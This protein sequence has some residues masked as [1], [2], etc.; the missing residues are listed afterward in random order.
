MKKLNILVLAGLLAISGTVCAS[1]SI[2]PDKLFNDYGRY[3]VICMDSGQRVYID[4]NTLLRDPAPAG[5]LPV[6][7]GTA[8]TEVYESLDF[9]AYGNNKMIKMIVESEIAVGAD[10]YGSDVKYSMLTQNKGA[11]DAGG[12][13]VPPDGE[14]INDTPDT[15]K[16]IYINM[17]R[18]AK[19]LT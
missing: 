7:R 3:A 9:P 14:A 4:T 12:T 11:Y 2:K 10:V 6:L 13:P 16:E 5:S 15:A 17:Y 19:S 18:L 1:P 8:Y